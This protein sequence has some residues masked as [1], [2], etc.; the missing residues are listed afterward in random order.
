MSIGIG[1]IIIIVLLIIL[2]FG[3]YPNISNEL[4]NGIKNIRELLKNTNQHETPKQ[5]SDKKPDQDTK[6]T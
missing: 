2:L 4:L 5:I 3:K 1:Q 6:N